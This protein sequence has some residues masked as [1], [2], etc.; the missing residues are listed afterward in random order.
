MDKL[1]IP[2]VTKQKLQFLCEVLKY[3]GYEL[4]AITEN[5]AMN[6][7]LITFKKEQTN[8]NRKN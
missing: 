3:N 2:K 6:N 1:Y 4:I 7:C 5:P 8:G